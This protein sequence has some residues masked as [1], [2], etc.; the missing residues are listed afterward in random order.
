VRIDVSAQA[1]KDADYRLSV[2]DVEAFEKAHGRIPAG[3]IVLLRTG[4]DARWP[5][6]LRYFGDAT[7]GDAAHL[8]FPSF[9]AEA[10]QRLIEERHVAAIGLDTASIDYGPSSDFPVHRLAGAANVVGLE[11]LAHLERVPPT[12]A[13]VIAL[14]MDIAGGSGGPLRIVALLPKH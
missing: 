7:P 2:A 14:P 9:G 1:S 13:V 10:A 4:W 6:R 11:N 8:H 5:D 3:S 12:G